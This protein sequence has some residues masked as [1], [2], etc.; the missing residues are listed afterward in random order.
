MAATYPLNPPYALAG[1]LTDP[2]DTLTRWDAMLGRR[3]VGGLIGADAHQRMAV[4]RKW[5][6]P[7]PSYRSVFRLARN[8][9]LLDRPLTGS[10]GTILAAGRRAAAFG[11]VLG[12]LAYRTGRLGPSIATHM[13]FNAVTAAVLL[14]SS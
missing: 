5:A 4:G 11:A 10:E 8:H 14:L 2:A 12:I 13:G 9:V 7:F 6:I 1:S 3:A